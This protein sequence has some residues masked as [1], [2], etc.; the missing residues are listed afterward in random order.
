[1]DRPGHGDGARLRG[2]DA[3]PWRQAEPIDAAVRSLGLHR[4]PV[5]V[6]AGDADNVV[7]PMMHG[8]LAARMI[9][10]PSFERLAGIGHMLHHLRSDAVA[11]AARAFLPRN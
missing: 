3:S 6:P 1:M 5:R 11:E 2:D 8:A 7:D 9:P 4:V 10:G